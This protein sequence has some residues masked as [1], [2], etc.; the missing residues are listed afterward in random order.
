MH[1]VYKGNRGGAPQNLKSPKDSPAL[2]FPLVFVVN[3]Q[4]PTTVLIFCYLVDE[5]KHLVFKVA[6]MSGKRKK[7]NISKYKTRIPDEFM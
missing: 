5:I 6:F 1:K 2:S 4:T 3:P 7:K